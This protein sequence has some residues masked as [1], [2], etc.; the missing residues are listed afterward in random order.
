MITQALP[1]WLILSWIN[2]P[3]M[4]V[5][6]GSYL[7]IRSFYFI[8]R[9]TYPAPFDIEKVGDNYPYVKNNSLTVVSGNPEF[10]DYHI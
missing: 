10:R 9:T 2:A 7:Q 4:Q 3:H 1:A 5:I 6:H 8:P